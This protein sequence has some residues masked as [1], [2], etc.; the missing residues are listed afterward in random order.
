MSDRLLCVALPVR[1]GANYLAAALDSI[2][3]QSYR[4]FDLF[5]SDN[6]STDETPAILAEFAARDPRVK[7]SRSADLISQQANM[8]RAMALADTPWVKLFCHDDM[9]LPDCLARI[10]GA[11]ER[12]SGSDVALIGNGERYLFG[13]RYMTDGVDFGELLILPGHEAIA[14]KLW[15]VARAVPFPAVTTATVRKDAF[16]E[17][18]G[19]DLRYVYFDSFCWLELLMRHDYAVDT[20]A[21]TINRIHAAQV[22]QQARRS[23]RE[24]SD[25]R[26]FLRDFVS[27][28]GAA[29]GMPGKARLRLRLMPV[30][31]AARAIAVQVRAGR[32]REALGMVPRL[33]LHY[34]PLLAI[35]VPRAGADERRITR[36]RAAHV[37][38]EFLYPG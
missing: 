21:L 12:V 26:E 9:M 1:N 27:R 10:V 35:L 32:I 4:D 11:I 20:Q 30:A 31:L 23:L 36:Q 14:R 8:N 38:I 34:W 33:P 2:L 6:A 7:V 18:G 16:L 5:V 17:A 24:V 19:F 15:N 13:D 37:P 28:H 29:L 25:F 22:A 3:A